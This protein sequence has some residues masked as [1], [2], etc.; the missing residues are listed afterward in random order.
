MYLSRSCQAEKYQALVEELR[1]SKLQLTLFQL[2]HNEKNIH[3]QSDSVRNIQEAA[4]QQKNSLD[5]WEQTVKA[6]K[7]EHGR[8]N[9]EL[10][11]LEK[12]IRRVT[13]NRL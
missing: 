12:E 13:V 11:Q 6:R 1:E 5:V 3:A 2:F 4:V 7:K 10:Q 8:L 9:R